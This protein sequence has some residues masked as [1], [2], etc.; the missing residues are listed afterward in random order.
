[1]PRLLV[2]YFLL[3]L[4]L[5]AQQMPTLPVPS[6][7]HPVGRTE[8]NL[9]GEILY[10]FYPV[11]KR[12][13]A[14]PYVPPA[15]LSELEKNGYY[16]QS[17]ETIA[18]WI[19]VKTHS[20]N[21]ASP[22]H[23]PLPLIIFLPGAGVMGFQYTAL[24]EE[25]ASHG[26]IFA[27]VDYFNPHS[28]NRSYSDTDGAAMENDMAHTA[29]YVLTALSLNPA[30]RKR[31]DANHVGIMGHSVGGAAAIAAPRIDHRFIASVDMDGGLFGESMKGAV[32]PLLVLR[33][34]P[35]YSNA[36]LTKRGLTRRQWE[37]RG[38]D[39]R[40]IFSELKARSHGVEVSVLSING[41]GHFSFSDAPF[42]MPDV[43]NR[44]GG[45]IIKPERSEHII[46]SCALE[47]FDHNLRRGLKG[48]SQ[49]STY[50]EVLPGS[51]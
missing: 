15:L 33:S 31:I 14:A 6:G 43:I 38:I 13:Q 35:I 22:I 18:S 42:V 45:K 24:A 49:C 17:V 21:S 47:F 28:S 44:F 26:Y 40:N 9:S 12:S 10:L 39:A 41:T 30:W 46:S 29:A 1:M 8:L 2:T 27:I 5:T 23:D 16:E 20:A 32:A 50:P 11:K 4:L 36:D 25:F 48:T 3:L 51:G 19:A 7:T 34:K 37:E